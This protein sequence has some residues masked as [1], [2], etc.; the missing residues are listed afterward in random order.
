MEETELL[1]ALDRRAGTAV[2]ALDGALAR[3]EPAPLPIDPERGRRRRW[4]PLLVAAGLVV[5]ALLGIGL[6]LDGRDDEQGTVADDRDVPVETDDGEITRLALADPAALGY[7]VRAAFAS[8][9][10]V[11]GSAET[12]PV[13]TAH[14][15][16]G[17]VDPWVDVVLSAAVPINEYSFYGELVD[18]GGPEATFVAVGST[19]QL[20]WRDGGI[21][22]QLVTADLDRDAMV[23]L[24]STAIEM[25]WDGRGALPGH[26]VLHTGPAQD[27][28]S[29]LEFAAGV[30]DD[31]AG[32]A[33][34]HEGDL[35]FVIGWSAGDEVRWHAVH[36]LT[37]TRQVEINGRTATVA[38]PVLNGATELSWLEDGTLVRVATYADVDVLVE[39]L[40]D[41]LVPISGEE[42]QALVAAHAP[43][44]SQVILEAPFGLSQ[45]LEGVPPVATISTSDSFGN[46]LRLELIEQAGGGVAMMMEMDDATG[47]SGSG[48]P[49]RD[50]A[51]PMLQ[52]GAL[53]DG[54]TGEPTS[55]VIVSG[56]IP[57]GIPEDLAGSRFIDRGTG[58]ALPLRQHV[59]G[60]IPGS[61]HRLLIA[62]VDA[63]P[64]TRVDVTFQTVDGERTWRL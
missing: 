18:V 35:D 59:T 22:R 1:E 27:F 60:D 25:G 13:F 32:I 29:N 53:S 46:E 45:P 44:E 62:V 24:A 5:V 33:Y 37:S 58:D 28:F 50:L 55:D 49:L 57:A 54:E 16:T 23:S 38:A 51:T 63:A 43:D 7:E 3:V 36:A 30:R 56:V 26:D 42:H 12:M 19:T 11:D 20:L 6:A 61:D 2:A 31:R 14:G 40:D 10:N 39:L 21:G 64:G 4:R 47:T 9:T 41:A 8:G 48:G 17:A 15:P 34:D 52:A